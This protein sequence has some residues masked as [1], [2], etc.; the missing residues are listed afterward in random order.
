MTNL[1][2]YKNKKKSQI[3]LRE[4]EEILKLFIETKKSLEIYGKYIPAKDVYISIMDNEAKV[5]L[6]I[7]KYKKLLEE[8]NESF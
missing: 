3:V 2:E 8:E 7:K 6:H 1:S 4:L 5:L